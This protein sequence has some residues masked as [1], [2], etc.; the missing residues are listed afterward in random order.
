M[1]DRKSQVFDLQDIGIT[2]QAVKVDAQRMGG[3]FSQQAGTQAPKGMGMVDLKVELLGQLAV[4]GFDNLPDGIE[5]ASDGFRGLIG[6]VGTRQRHEV[7]TIVMQQLAG[8]FSTDIA[9]VTKDGQVGMLSQQ[10]RADVQI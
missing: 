7:E 6:L 8:Q 10:L 2:E 3:E 1:L 5:G 4:D 9:F